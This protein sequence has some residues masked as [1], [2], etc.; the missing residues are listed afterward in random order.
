MRMK[1]LM[2]VLG[3]AILGGFI[4]K[5]INVYTIGFER[6]FAKIGT[7]IAGLLLWYY[8]RGKWIEKVALGMGSY[9]IARGIFDPY[10]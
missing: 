5:P 4:E 7:G 9:L 1:E 10:Y 8:T 2:L 6:K 3:G